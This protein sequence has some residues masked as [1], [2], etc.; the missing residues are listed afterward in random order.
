M[1]QI[2]VFVSHASEDKGAIARPIAEALSK[3]YKVWFD[4]Y[5]LHVGDSLRAKIDEGLKQ[6]DFG[7][8]VL[9]ESFFSKKWPKAELDGLLALETENKK[10]ILPVWHEVNE[11]QVKAF[12]PMLAGRLGATS[13]KGVEQ[14]VKELTRSISAS[15][16]TREITS[17]STGRKAILNVSKK[18]SHKEAEQDFLRSEAGSKAAQAGIKDI[19]DRLVADAEAANSADPKPRFAIKRPAPLDFKLHAPYRLTLGIY[20]AEF[21]LNSVS[22]AKLIAGFSK[23]GDFGEHT[24]HSVAEIEWRPR[25]TENGGV[26]WETEET[27][28]RFT[29]GQ[30]ADAI[31]QKLSELLEEEMDENS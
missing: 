8:V 31:L 26:C 15:V 28:Q 10:L 5:E 18:L 17:E 21:Y 4:E 29:N 13:S 7:V 24:G 16:R 3:D 22:N 25:Y 12:S 20:L 23:R 2:K 19:I 27:N 11:A 14:V 30:V 6:C 9:S 1:S